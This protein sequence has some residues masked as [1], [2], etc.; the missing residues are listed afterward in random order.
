MRFWQALVIAQM[1]AGAIHADSLG[2]HTVGLLADALTITINGVFWWVG[3]AVWPVTEPVR[4]A[5]KRGLEDFARE[6]RR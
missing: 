3:S 1:T 2:S 5:V 4:V 6:Y